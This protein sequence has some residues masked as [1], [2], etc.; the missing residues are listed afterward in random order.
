MGRTDH[1]RTARREASPLHRGHRGY[2]RHEPEETEVKQ[3]EIYHVLAEGAVASWKV[4]KEGAVLPL[5]RT[6]SKDA[7]VRAA[8]R[9]A[10]SAAFGRV[11]VHRRDGTV[12]QEIRYGEKT[13]HQPG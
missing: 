3:P 2:A 10:Q 6:Q 4:E 9:L 7:A 13:G 1:A 8:K 5:T 12:Q 11:V